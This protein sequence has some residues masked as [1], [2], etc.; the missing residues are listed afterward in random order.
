[1]ATHIP[2]TGMEHHPDIV[3]LRERY[4]RATSTPRAQGIEALAVL[5]GLFLAASPWIVGFT[6]YN[7]L[8]VTCLIV[9]L[10]YTALMAGYGSAYERTHARAWAAAALGV[11]T[12]I[13]PWVVS[14][15]VAHGK[16]IVT[17]IIAGAVMF[18]LGLAAI[19][20]A[21]MTSNGASM[22]RGRAGRAKG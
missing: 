13:S 1:M 6:A 7:T 15:S 20:M 3:E 21:T 9:G 10:A 14:G 4:E 22:R 16:N 12:I 18:L 5:A 11:W 17:C 8:T 19:S 2:T